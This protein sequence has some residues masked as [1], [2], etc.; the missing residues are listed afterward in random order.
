MKPTA[1]QRWILEYVDKGLVQVRRKDT[2]QE[3]WHIIRKTEYMDAKHRQASFREIEKLK[4]A[5]WIDYRVDPLNKTIYADGR[6]ES[7]HR[8][9]LTPAGRDALGVTP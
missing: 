5:G 9:T 2:R 3:H 4:A 1:R 7:H 8:A 6:E